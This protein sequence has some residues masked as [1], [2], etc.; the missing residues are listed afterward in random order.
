MARSTSVHPCTGPQ[1]RICIPL[2]PNRTGT[3][4]QRAGRATR[5]LWSRGIYPS[6]SAVN[7]RMRGQ[8]RD[9]LNGIETT[10][11]NEVVDQLG[12]TRQRNDKRFQW[13]NREEE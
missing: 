7:M 11:R 10:A 9:C 1:P 6:P 4:A 8:P 12:I 2:D 13:R 5:W 3:V